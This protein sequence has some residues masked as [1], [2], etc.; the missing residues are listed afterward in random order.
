[1]SDI[2]IDAMV[3]KWIKD[4]PPVPAGH[5]WPELKQA[6]D[7]NV[8]H[9]KLWVTDIT[10]CPRYVCYRVLG[11]KMKPNTAAEIAMFDLANYIHWRMCRALE[12]AGLLVAEELKL[13]MPEPWGGRLDY[14]RKVSQTVLTLIIGDGKTIHPRG[15]KRNAGGEVPYELPK[16]ESQYQVS[17]Y[18]HFLDTELL[19]MLADEDGLAVPYELDDD[20]VEIIHMDRGGQN[21][22]YPTL[23]PVIPRAYIEARMRGVE[24]WVARAEA[25]KGM[26]MP[27]ILQ[28]V[29][30]WGTRYTDKTGA[31]TGG[32]VQ[33]NCFQCNYCKVLEC[34]ANRDWPRELGSLTKT[35]GWTPTE[36]G[37]RQ[38]DR[39]DE[40]IARDARRETVDD[41]LPPL[42]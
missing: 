27:P 10:K 31:F 3:A 15:L 22:S 30:G 41:E 33:E 2:D 19:D 39:V 7:P 13:N 29:I 36:F 32:K 25:S 12:H 17:T 26:D 40:F 21:P 20:L 23:T 35:K 38:Q 14:L 18:W 5:E 34:P 4:K 28:P 24:G 9:S 11:A 1:M 37:K 8:K 42:A 16:R 6:Y